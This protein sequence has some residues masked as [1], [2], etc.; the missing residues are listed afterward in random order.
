MIRN[1]TLCEF[2][3]NVTARVLSERLIDRQSRKMLEEFNYKD[4]LWQTMYAANDILKEI[5]ANREAWARIRG[6]RLYIFNERNRRII[7][8]IGLDSFDAGNRKRKRLNI[9]LLSRT[10][11]KFHA[12]TIGDLIVA[13]AK[14]GNINRKYHNKR[15][16][17]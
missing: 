7:C 8:E 1:P 14:V 5:G 2:E 12:K 13:S 11:R 6:D 9:I 10:G 3:L 4:A 17:R 15:K 16:G